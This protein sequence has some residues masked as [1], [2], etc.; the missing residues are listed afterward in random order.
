MKYLKVKGKELLRLRLEN[1]LTQK[2]MAAKVNTTHSTISR[3]E[4][5]KIS[6][7]PKTALSL[8]KALNCDFYE[9]FFILEGGK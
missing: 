4:Q 6:I 8:C 2:E 3:A 5:S 9:M 7:N 1:G